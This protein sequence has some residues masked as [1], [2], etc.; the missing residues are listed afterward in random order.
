VGFIDDRDPGQCHIQGPTHLRHA[1]SE[2]DSNPVFRRKST[3]EVDEANVRVKVLLVEDNKLNQA[4]VKTLLERLG[5][6]VLL[7]SHFDFLTNWKC[8]GLESVNSSLILWV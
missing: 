7:Y 4:L 2:V 5:C 6:E 8:G 3:G 1:M